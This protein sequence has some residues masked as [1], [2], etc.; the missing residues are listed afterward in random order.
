VL[1]DL[2]EFKNINDTHGHA[3]GDEVLRHFV[4]HCQAQL[5]PQDQFGRIGGE[6]FLLVLPHTQAADAWV[7]TERL[8]LTLEPADGLRYTFSAGVAGACQ[9]DAL[10]ALLERADAAL[11]EAKRS[12]R[13]RCVT[14]SRGPG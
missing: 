1:I 14:A 4:A 11:Y 13:N 2:D 8:R 12:G 5:R 9:G 6:E 7:A 3:A 10:N